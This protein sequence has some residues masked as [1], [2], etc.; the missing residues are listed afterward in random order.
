MKSEIRLLSKKSTSQKIKFADLETGQGVLDENGSLRLR[1]GYDCYLQF[2]PYNEL[3]PQSQSNWPEDTT[4]KIERF[5]LIAE[6][7]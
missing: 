1:V 6:K 2:T 5:K 4:G 3:Y 7:I